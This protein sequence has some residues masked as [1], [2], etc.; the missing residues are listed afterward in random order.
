MW[1]TDISMLADPRENAKSMDRAWTP[2]LEECA[3]APQP[4]I[5]AIL[6]TGCM[7]RVEGQVYLQS[8][9]LC[10]SQVCMNLVCV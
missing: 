5:N 7:S 4:S 2:L 3:P 10:T 9:R 6:D 8:S 1:W